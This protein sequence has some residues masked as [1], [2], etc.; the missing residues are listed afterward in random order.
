MAVLY[1][2]SDPDVAQAMA[3]KL[4]PE[5]SVLELLK[6]TETTRTIMAAATDQSTMGRRLQQQETQTD[7]QSLLEMLRELDP[8]NLSGGSPPPGLDGLVEVVGADALLQV[9]RVLNSVPKEILDSL[10]VLSDV[11]T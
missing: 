5:S 4:V 10:V 2:G 8:A 3:D 1:T 7:M 6:A 9:I 11:R